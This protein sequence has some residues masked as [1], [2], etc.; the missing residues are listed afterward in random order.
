[1]K[2][3]LLLAAVA[4][5][6]VS[7]AQAAVWVGPTAPPGSAGGVWTTASNW[8]PADVPDT[9]GESAVFQADQTANRAIT[10]ASGTITTLSFDTTNVAANDFTNS[11]AGTL[12]LGSGPA[13][14]AVTG[15]GT[16]LTTVSAGLTLSDIVTVNVTNTTSTSAAGALTFTGTVAGAGGI[17]KTGGGLFTL[18][19]AA[20]TYTGPTLV[21]G[22]K[23]RISA[24]A[25]P[26]GTSSFTLSDGTQ[27]NFTG[28]SGTVTLGT[29]TV[30]LT[31]NGP[32]TNGGAIRP[33]RG[34]GSTAQDYVIPN[35]VSLN[36]GS[37]NTVTIHVQANSGSGGGGAPI[38]TLTLSG[39]VSG[40]AQLVFT[41]PNSDIDQGTLVL[42][43]AAGNT[44]A[45]GTLIEGGILSVTGGSAGTAGLGSGNV[46]VSD[47]ASPTSI[48]R[49]SIPNAGINAISDTAT[50]S[51]AGGG[52]GGVADE[53]FVV[54]GA[55]VNETVGG[56]ILGGVTQAPGTYGSTA[57][58][59]TFQNN[60]YF[61]GSGI[62]TV[63]P[64]PAALSLV[65]VG[66]M[67]LFGRRRK[68]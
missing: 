8:S 33:E 30:A 53:N 23:I 43:R 61:S 68:Q 9:S 40:A 59:A 22:G 2:K 27:L 52:T 57:S 50:L 32:A 58:A 60:E 1:M 20:K 26:T 14:V 13:T 19:T 29:G 65:A 12:T 54:L 39:L 62:L 10:G 49:L 35:A 36:V 63:T 37:T 11:V 67:G 34:S 24:A 15:N 44:Y 42:S 5:L 6:S 46:T 55:G 51:L 47:A 28:N 25:A 31:G 48:A 16:K 66:A 38:G 3:A 45:G 18:G 56:L 17:T 41:A 21:S 64:E 4:G 7:Y